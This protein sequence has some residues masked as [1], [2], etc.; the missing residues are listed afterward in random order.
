MALEQGMVKVLVLG[1]YL[2][3]PPGELGGCVVAHRLARSVGF[4]LLDS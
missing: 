4:N 3:N 1:S 2:P